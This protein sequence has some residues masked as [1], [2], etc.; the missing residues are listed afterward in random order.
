MHSWPIITAVRG[1]SRQAPRLGFSNSHS[2]AIVTKL[3][4]Q[5]AGAFAIIVIGMCFV[6]WASVFIHRSSFVGIDGRRYFCLFDDAM[7]SMR[8]AWNLSHGLGLVWNPGEYVEGYTNP[9]MTLLM[10]L[11][12]LVFDKVGAV[13]AIQILGVIFML[14]NAY[15]IM[16][17]AGTLVSRQEQYRGL[18]QALGFLCG[19][20]YYPLVYWSLMGMETGLLTVLL[21][22]SVLLALRYVRDLKPMHGVLLSISLGLAFLTRTDAVILA[23]PIFIYV[24][25]A[26]RK[27]ERSP[28]L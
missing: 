4:P 14:A 5:S 26:V 20:S 13:L 11:P 15:L 23:V 12:T 7:I 24:F 1:N 22:L 25:Y 10:S 21:S 18:F 6:A 17:I 2:G 16:L 9:L 27:S 28:S 3:S 8:Y 19:L